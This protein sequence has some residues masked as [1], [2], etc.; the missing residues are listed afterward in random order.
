MT[1]LD[2]RP[3][4][5]APAPPDGGSPTSPPQ[6]SGFN[7]RVSIGLFAG[8]AVLFGVLFGLRA[9]H[10]FP[11]EPG[12]DPEIVAARATQAV[13]GTQEALAPRPTAAAAVAPA[14][15]PTA[16]PALATS[17]ATP[18][19]P[20]QPAA[21]PQNAPTAAAA[22]EAAPAAAPSTP[23]PVAT[24][25]S[26][27]TAVSGPTSSPTGPTGPT[28]DQVEPTPVAIDLP[29]DLARA[30]LNGFSNYW[31]VRVNAMRDPNDSSVDLESV[32]SDSELAG[33]R[34]TLAEYR[35]AGEA[36]DTR[37]SHTIWITSATADEAVIVDQYTANALKLDLDTKV[38]L[39]ASPT[40]ETRTDT[41]VLRQMDGVWKVVN[42][43]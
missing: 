38:P 28:A 42:E 27:P 37:V 24:A 32:M 22:I 40:P 30:I 19:L 10:I 7:W 16:V 5:R 41:F 6:D 21:G 26:A 39:E 12:Q 9:L 3:P 33:A 2:P 43:P 25:P 35:D 17:A 8:L 34:K 23:Q 14:A 1:Q 31:S 4:T 36:F 20:L 18:A 11:P 13:L 29:A 15:A